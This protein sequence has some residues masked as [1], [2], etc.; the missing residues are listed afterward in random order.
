MRFVLRVAVLFAIALVVLGAPS[1]GRASVIAFT[2]FDEP[3]SGAA[4][5]TAGS[6]SPGHELGFTIG[7]TDPYV[8]TA[9]DHTDATTDVDS[10]DG[11]KSYYLYRT[12]TNSLIFDTVNLSSYTGVNLS[13]WLY[14]PDTDFESNDYLTMTLVFNGDTTFTLLDI[15]GGT[16]DGDFAPY[17][18]QWSKIST[19]TDDIPDAKTSV[20]LKIKNYMSDGSEDSWVD[21]IFITPEPATLALMGFGTAGILWVRRR[22]AGKRSR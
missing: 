7:D 19:S 10:N 6:T 4:T 1:L 22:R 5:Y 2:N 14:V 17:K 11:D 12:T 21:D 3:A 18:G 20:Y 13:L 9:R 8:S 15:W 16:N